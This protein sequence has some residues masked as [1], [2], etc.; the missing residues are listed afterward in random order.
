VDTKPAVAETPDE[1]LVDQARGG[2]DEALNRLISRHHGVAY[3]V[4]LGIL[5]DPDAA[6]DAA[7]DGFMKAV[8]ALD[9]FRGESRFRT[10]LVTIVSNEARGQLRKAGRRRESGLEDVG[11]L[12][13]GAPRVD[14]AVTTRAEAER[15]RAFLATLPEKQRLSVQLRLD[16]GLSFREVGEIIG[17]SEGAA[18]VNYH[19][20]IRRLREMMET[21]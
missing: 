9:R 12:A 2:D 10:W 17:S 5:R 11:P 14:D 21:A 18:R 13:D 3:R 19:H 20:G 1:V 4:A 15:A 6:A 8:R 16:E 7:Q